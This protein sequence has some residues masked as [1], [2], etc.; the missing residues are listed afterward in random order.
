MP[1]ADSKN[2]RALVKGTL[3]YS[4]GNFGTKILAFLIVPLYT[5]YIDPESMG[6]YD[7]VQ[8]TVNLFAPFVTLRISDAAYRWMLHGIEDNQKCI[9]A[10]YR[11]MALSSAIS[12]IILSLVELIYPITYFGYF[13]LLL[14]LGRWLDTMQM[15][16]RG[17]KKQKLFAISG[18]LYTII[19]LALNV[20][21]VVVMHKGIESLFLSMIIAELVTIFFLI[22]LTRELRIWFGGK[23][24]IKPLIKEML[25]YSVPLI[26]SAI[27]WWVMSASDRYVIRFFLGRYS[28]GIYAIANKFPTIVSTIFIIFN[29]SW[30]DVAIGDLNEGK[31]TTE[32]SSK[33]FKHLYVMSFSFLLFLIPFTKFATTVI[34]PKSYEE[35]AIYIGFLYIGSVFQG[36]TAFISA[37]MLQKNNT[38]SIAKSSI[39][40]AVVNL[41]FDL[42]MMNF[43][44]LH[45]ASV[46][47]FLGGLVMWWI[48]M[49]DLKDVA[50]IN[51]NYKLFGLYLLLNVLASIITIWTPPAVDVVISSLAFL[52]FVFMYRDI[53]IK[54]FRKIKK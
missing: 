11:I 40:G 46:S 45:A 31:E 14:I 24:T 2:N 34:L 51:I 22:A 26:P 36:F 19:Y 20:L 54:A 53:I 44:G 23:E 18:L 32:Y 28:T 1:S 39:I 30:T 8:T 25:K 43:I 12:V 9:K 41:A 47:T 38:K 3:I 10:A 49:R 6:D 27:C 16:L 17:L 5:Y 35:S 52:Y 7:L 48:R 4:V 50:P 37:G 13:V 15:L 29:S 33:L 42:I 21:F